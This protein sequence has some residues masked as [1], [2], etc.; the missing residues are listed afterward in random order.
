MFFGVKYSCCAFLLLLLGCSS[1]VHH[2]DPGAAVPVILPPVLDGA[3]PVDP[4]S[5]VPPNEASLTILS[6]MTGTN[7]VRSELDGETWV[8]R[9]LVS[10]EVS[11]VNR[12]EVE[13]TGEDGSRREVSEPWT[14]TLTLRRDGTRTILARGLDAEGMELARAEVQVN[15]EAP[16]DT[17]CQAMLAVDV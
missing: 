1:E 11:G 6:P 2:S 13:V 16:T 17:S 4:D 14:T 3:P 10:L 5:S 12:V 9:V 8:A 15:V 7:L